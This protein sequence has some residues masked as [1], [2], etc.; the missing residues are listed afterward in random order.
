MPTATRRTYPASPNQQS[1]IKRLQG[2]RGLPVVGCDTNTTFREASAMIE[3]LMS[4]PRQGAA[5]PQANRTSG[6]ATQDLAP[7][8]DTR[9]ANMLRAGRLLCTLTGPD[10]RHVTLMFKGRVKRARWERAE[11]AEA[12]HIFITAGKDGDKVA[13]Y[14][15]QDRKFNTTPERFGGDKLRAQAAQAVL[16]HLAGIR[17]LRE[18]ST[19]VAADECG[20]CGRTL[21]DPISIGRGIGPECWGHVTGSQHVGRGQA[22]G[23]GVV[24]DEVAQA[25]AESARIRGIYEEGLERQVEAHGAERVID[26]IVEDE[27]LSGA[28]KHTLVTLVGQMAPGQAAL[29][30]PGMSDTERADAITAAYDA[31]DTAEAK[32]LEQ[33]DPEYNT[34]QRARFGF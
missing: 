9:E 16:M 30:I 15:P 7:Q 29:A 6:E 3:A 17:P 31:G 26:G 27:R 5:A 32:R 22:Q 23:A 12:T 2:E 33:E 10:G 1:L 4:L 28:D 25:E 18:G 11:F 34:R 8:L 20:R 14:Y 13:T 19:L 24:A 21:T